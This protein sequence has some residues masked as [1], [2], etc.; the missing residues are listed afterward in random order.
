MTQEEIEAYA[1][2]M[3]AAS[4]LPYTLEGL[5]DG[6]KMQLQ[7]LRVNIVAQCIAACGRPIAK[8]E[9]NMIAKAQEAFDRG[10]ASGPA[11]I[12]MRDGAFGSDQS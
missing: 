8:A 6:V 2:R 4:G 12:L 5:D 1:K 7:S 11:P 10:R 3:L 9:Q